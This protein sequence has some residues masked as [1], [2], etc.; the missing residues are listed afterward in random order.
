MNQIPDNS[1]DYP[2]E[3][4][5][6]LVET[7]ERLRKDIARA[8]I[9]AAVH[10]PESL[11]LAADLA[12]ARHVGIRAV[13]EA[14]TRARR[15]SSRAEE[16]QE[17][18]RQR[19]RIDALMWERDALERFTETGEMNPEAERAMAEFCKGLAMKVEAVINGDDDWIDNGRNAEEAE[20]L[21]EHYRSVA[22]KAVRTG[23]LRPN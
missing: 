11:K 22:R 19:A 21:R 23:L 8:E 9:S 20:T 16:V 2:T 3:S 5:A 12:Q 15:W 1:P 13:E 7:A 4:E 14:S 10:G 6:V 18:E 17:G